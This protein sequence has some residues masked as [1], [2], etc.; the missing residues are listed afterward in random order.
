[1]LSGTFEMD[2]WYG[3]FFEWFLKKKYENLKIQKLSKN[4]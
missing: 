3:G 2:K 4:S 1:M